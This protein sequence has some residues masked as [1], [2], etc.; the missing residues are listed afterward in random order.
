MM[1][2][3]DSKELLNLFYNEEGANEVSEQ[4]MDAYNS[5]VIGQSNA[6][7]VMEDNEVE[8]GEI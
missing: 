6:N 7:F 5:G 3:R 4:I 1:K 2:K 8:E